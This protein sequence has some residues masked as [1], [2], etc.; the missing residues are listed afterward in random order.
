MNTDDN[1]TKSNEKI[2]VSLIAFP[3]VLVELVLVLI[4]FLL[5]GTPLFFGAV[6][7][8]MAFIPLA[9]GAFVGGALGKRLGGNGKS[10]A[11]GAVVGSLLTLALG[12]LW[13][14]YR[15]QSLN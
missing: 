8:I 9:V 6:F 7:S 12:Y 14:S 11:I 2:D 13:L 3:I 4:L 15:T 10:V 5:T 1:S